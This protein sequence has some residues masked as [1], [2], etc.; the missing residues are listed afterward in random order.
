MNSTMSISENELVCSQKPYRY[1]YCSF[2]L[3]L[4]GQTSLLDSS[5]QSARECMLYDLFMFGLPV[6][7]NLYFTSPVPEQHMK[8]SSGGVNSVDQLL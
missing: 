2:I 3:P 8:C 7:S 4:T 5:L 6:V 1:L